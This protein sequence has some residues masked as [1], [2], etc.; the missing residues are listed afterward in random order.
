MPRG[1]SL[2]ASEADSG[3]RKSV[4]KTE[5]RF[6]PPFLRL[7][8]HFN[9]PAAS[10]IIRAVHR[11]RITPNQLTCLSF[12]SGLGAAFI[13]FQGRPRLFLVA[14]VLAQLAS[15]ID[16]ADGMLARVRGQASRFGAYLDLVLDRVMEFFL[17]TGAAYGFFRATGRISPFIVGLVAGGLYFLQ[18]SLFYLLKPYFGESRLG[19]TDESRAWLMFLIFIFS[20]V[21]RL[22]WG[23]YSLFA[24]SLAVNTGAVIRFLRARK[25]GD[26]PLP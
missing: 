13:F 24:A 6:I 10:L 2:P 25:A 7:N 16:C 17:I 19:D 26:A 9:R 12:L 14:G 21:N 11:T 15:I 1:K 5:A 18:T 3:I 4:D 8:R 22:D 20:A 23:F